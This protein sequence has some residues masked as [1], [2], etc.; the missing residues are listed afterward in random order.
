MFNSDITYLV[1]FFII[2]FV[3]FTLWSSQH[4]YACSERLLLYE[5]VHDCCHSFIVNG[6]YIVD[7]CVSAGSML[8]VLLMTMATASLSAS[9]A[10]FLV[11][12]RANKSKHVQVHFLPLSPSLQH[13]FF[14]NRNLFVLLHRTTTKMWGKPAKGEGGKPDA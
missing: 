4:G 10:V 5:C 1:L 2:V 12:E 11:R 3:F 9:F 14:P 13:W 7:V 8:L 6:I